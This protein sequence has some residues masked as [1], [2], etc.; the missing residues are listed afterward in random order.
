MCLLNGP[1]SFT[2]TL[3]S[4]QEEIR[5]CFT[6]TQAATL[7]TATISYTNN[8]GEG[9]RPYYRFRSYSKPG[10]NPREYFDK[11]AV[12]SMCIERADKRV[13][14]YDQGATEIQIPPTTSRVIFS[15][16]AYGRTKDGAVPSTLSRRMLHSCAVVPGLSAFHIRYDDKDYRYTE[17]PT[18]KYN[19]Q[20]FNSLKDTITTA[21]D[22]SSKS[23][24]TPDRYNIRAPAWETYV[25]SSNI[26]TRAV[27]PADTHN[28]TT[29]V[30]KEFIEFN[31]LGIGS[32]VTVAGAAG[33]GAASINSADG[34]AIV[35]I[36]ENY[37]DYT[38]ELASNL[39][40]AVNITANQNL[41]Y[42]RAEDLVDFTPREIDIHSDTTRYNA[43]Q[44]FEPNDSDSN[45]QHEVFNNRAPSSLLV[46]YTVG[47]GLDAAK[48]HLS[49]YRFYTSQLTFK[50][51]DSTKTTEFR[52][53]QPGV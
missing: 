6:G 25:R 18:S 39:E 37:D 46:G 52:M 15:P 1:I 35:S 36:T 30:S 50:Y 28:F 5:N 41:T 12:Y 23:T 3:I 49:Y 26:P 43:Y 22:F 45:L 33:D 4:Q 38:I 21:Q 2:F 10:F 31:D 7:D 17:D 9:L 13:Y 44:V 19:L 34:R 51:E 48:L 16:L 14:N 29:T 24:L 53:I 47:G 27:A 8:V 32:L 42:G 11:N 40:G 20:I